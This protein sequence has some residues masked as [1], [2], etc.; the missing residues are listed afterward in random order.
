MGFYAWKGKKE[1]K[2]MNLRKA[3][4]SRCIQ[5]IKMTTKHNVLKVHGHNSYAHE[6]LKFDLVYLLRKNKVNIATEVEFKNGG[7]CDILDL[8]NS[9]IYEVLNTETLEDFEDKKSSYPKFLKLIPVKVGEFDMR[10]L[11]KFLGVD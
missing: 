1:F 2:R 5:V 7:R 10:A 9:V 8:D 6:K 11:I 4:Y 3:N